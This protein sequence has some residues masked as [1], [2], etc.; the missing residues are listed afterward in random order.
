MANNMQ[1]ADAQQS[2]ESNNAGST[3]RIT[4][5][6]DEEIS[7]QVIVNNAL[8]H[9][10]DDQAKNDMLKGVVTAVVAA[11][12][13]VINGLQQTVAQLQKGSSLNNAT[14]DVIQRHELKQDDLEQYSKRDNIIINGIPETENEVTN[15]TVINLAKDLGVQITSQDI[16]TSHR[17][18][19]PRNDKIRPIVAK[20]VRRDVRTNIL[21]K[22]AISPEQTRI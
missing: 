13:P 20:F 14:K 2:V 16:S 9:L 17:L 18:G 6:A 3:N 7:F 11:F 15:E 1:S 12:M 5:D 22:K 19:K 8:G 4:V 21:K 10:P